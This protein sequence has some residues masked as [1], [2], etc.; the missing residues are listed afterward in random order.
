ML[1][2]FWKLNEMRNPLAKTASKN[3]KVKLSEKNNLKTAVFEC[4]MRPS[5][6]ARRLCLEVLDENRSMGKSQCDKLVP[7]EKLQ[8]TRVYDEHDQ[9]TTLNMPTT[10]CGID[11]NQDRG[12]YCKLP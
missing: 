12:N 5:E 9:H 11:T 1:L 7:P 6:R 3:L 4:A 10:G 2:H 8:T